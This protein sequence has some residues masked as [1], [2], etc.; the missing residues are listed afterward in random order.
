MK[1]S[2]S[3]SSSRGELSR[4][5]KSSEGTHKDGSQ[6]A[7]DMK[8]KEMLKELHRLTHQVQVVISSGST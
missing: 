6:V 3:G 2:G 8:L 4:E 5:S 7:S 1:T